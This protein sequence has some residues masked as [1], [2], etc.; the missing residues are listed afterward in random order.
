MN[1]G[2]RPNLIRSSGIT[3]SSNSVARTSRRERTS[4]ANPICFFRSVWQRCPR[5]RESPSTKEQDVRGVDLNE[6]LVGVLATTLGGTDGDRPF[7]DLQQSL[8]NAFT[9]RHPE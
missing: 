5:A 8:L 2:I 9:R 7:E 1:S 4:A 6:F 3:C